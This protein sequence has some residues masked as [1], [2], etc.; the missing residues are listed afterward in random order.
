MNLES[1]QNLRVVL[2]LFCFEIK[3]F[4]IKLTIKYTR[5]VPAIYR[6]SSGF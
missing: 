5:I 2:N 3:W 1:D 6:W 4:M